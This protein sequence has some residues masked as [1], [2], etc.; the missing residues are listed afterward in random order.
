[1]IIHFHIRYISWP[2]QA[3]DPLFSIVY[4]LQMNRC[5]FHP[6]YIAKTDKIN[7]YKKKENRLLND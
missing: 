1:M 4:Y 7:M 3:S 2:L 5:V 6:L